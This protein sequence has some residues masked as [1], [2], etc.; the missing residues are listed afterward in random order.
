MV[1]DQV[2]DDFRIG[3]GSEAVPKPPQTFLEREIVFD[4]AIVDDNH[5]GRVMGVGVGLR[6]T[7]VG[8]PA[9][10][11]DAKGAAQRTFGKNLLKVDQLPPR[12]PDFDVAVVEGG[13]TGRVVA[14]VFEAP[15]PFENN[16]GRLLRSDISNNSAHI[17]LASE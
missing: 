17:N 2:G 11:A 9:G 1:G 13:D 15:Q 5:S 4:D 8:R 16:G 6:G 10:V 7:A 12:T 3:L 14:A